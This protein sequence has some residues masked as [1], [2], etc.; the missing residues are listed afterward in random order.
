VWQTEFLLSFRS[1]SKKV[2]RVPV[3]KINTTTLQ[4]ACEKN[5]V[6]I[7]GELPEIFL[8]HAACLSRRAN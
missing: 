4:T 8:H 7:L 2:F 5:A 1:T 6:C 3:D